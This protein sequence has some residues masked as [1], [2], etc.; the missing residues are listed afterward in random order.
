MAGEL[1]YMHRISCTGEPLGDV[2]HLHRCA[3]ESLN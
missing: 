2:A 1:W 3:T